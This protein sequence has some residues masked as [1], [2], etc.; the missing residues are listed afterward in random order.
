LTQT[1]QGR[2]GITLALPAAQKFAA[3]ARQIANV[4]FTVAANAIPATTQ[5]SFGDQPISRQ[6]VDASAN[7]LP[8]TY[9]SG[10]VTV[11]PGYEADVAPRPNGNNNGAVTIADWV[12]I[13]RFAAGLDTAAAGSEFQRADCA[14]K[15]SL[16]D[17]RI[18]LADWVQAGRYAAGIDAVVAAGG[19]TT[20]TS[21]LQLADGI[22]AAA[23]EQQQ[24]R[25]VRAV[26]VNILRGQNGM[27]L[28]ELDAQG[29]EN[30]L[31]FSLSFDPAQL[32]FVSAVAGSGATGSSLNVN[33]NQAANGR[34]GIALAMPA[35]QTLAAGTKQLLV[36]TFA[37]LT[38][39]SGA[40]TTV[41]IG[42][43]PV[44]RE[45][46]DAAANS[47]NASWAAATITL[48]RTVASVSAASFNGEVLAPET[49]VAAFGSNL[50]SAT[51]IAS[52]VP[53]PTSLAGSSVK[54]RDGAGVERLAPLFFVAPNQ[55]NYLV[56]ASTALGEASITVTSGD[57]TMSSGK[58][59]IA[60][61]APG[62][63][64]AN[65][66]GQ[67][68]AAAV[69]LRVKANGTQ[70]YEELSRYDATQQRFVSVPIDVGPEG[71]QVFLILYG[72]GWRYRSSLSAVTMKIG[73]VNAETSYAGL[74]GDYA[75]LDQLNVRLPRSLAG[76]GEVDVVL[77]VDG[78][79]ANVVR[80]SVK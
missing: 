61:I 58:V 39:G 78:T 56:P 8:A 67:G 22:E 44:G 68:V 36:V 72:T 80:V 45:I 21:G 46:V 60:N 15:A 19:P 41:A 4:S 12:L 40:T 53:L 17:G 13:G 57:G 2:L 59:R 48:A 18:T 24:A 23:E 34:V 26:N 47:L 69:V 14:P 6:V 74:Q 29:N 52:T 65:A 70:I 28:I 31:G 64:S 20:P 9:T 51:Q 7:I 16:G 27:L 32:S 38:G 75:G 50:A 79:A 30:A 1:A 55:V 71:D 11:T 37:A 77:S 5:I 66:S 62:L 25:A 10:A 33:T 63:F 35:N 49:I 73:G 3:G 42:D 76:R 54:V 43:Q